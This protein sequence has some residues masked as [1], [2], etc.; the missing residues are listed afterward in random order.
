MKTMRTLPRLLATA[1][2]ML[3]EVPR[4]VLDFA[5]AF[6]APPKGMRAA[7]GS[8]RTGMLLRWDVRHQPQGAGLVG[9]VPTDAGNARFRRTLWADQIDAA[10]EVGDILR[11]KA[12][13]DPG[14][15]RAALAYLQAEK[16]A[17]RAAEVAEEKAAE[18][19]ET[20]RRRAKLGE[21]A[22]SALKMYAGL[23]GFELLLVERRTDEALKGKGLIRVA[24]GRHGHAATAAGRELLVR[25]GVLAAGA[26]AA[27][28]E[29][30]PMTEAVKAIVDHGRLGDPDGDELLRSLGFGV[31]NDATEAA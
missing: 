28:G 5:R 18:L 30:M 2:P 22:W 24:W 27:A 13:G 20:T 14:A 3:T 26:A 25:A 15:G 23:P 4:E 31:V 29:P 16:A 10:G 19:E 21:T 6:P 17:E 7:I 1:R 12:A 11:L 8:L 9:E